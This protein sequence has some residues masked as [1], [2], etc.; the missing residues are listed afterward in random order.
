MEKI[1]MENNNHRKKKVD[2]VTLLSF[3]VAIFAIISL[4]AVGFNQVSFA[5]DTTL[6]G[7]ITK[8]KGGAQDLDNNEYLSNEVFPVIKY[9]AKYCENDATECSGSEK[10]VQVFCIQRD[11]D[12]GYGAD[13]TK[14]ATNDLS[15]NTG[16]LYLIS[17]LLGAGVEPMYNI[18]TANSGSNDGNKLET[19]VTQAAIWYYL[20]KINF[21]GNDV[22]GADIDKVMTSNYILYGSERNNGL[23]DAS[24]SPKVGYINKE[25]TLMNGYKVKGTDT[26]VEALVNE[27]IRLNT[28]NVSL[29]SFVTLNIADEGDV[30]I[31]DNEEYYFSKKVI[32][33]GAS[34]NLAS[35]KGFSITLPDDAPEGTIITDEEGTEIKDLT[36]IAPGTKFFIRVPIDSVDEAI[37]M[38][39]SIKGNFDIAT[40]NVFASA[41]KQSVGL[42]DYV[43]Y[44]KDATYKL[45]FT[46][47]P[48]TGS[49]MA[50]TIY[51]I[52]LIVLLCGVG[53]VYANA[54]NTKVKE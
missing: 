26:T 29:D 47:A 52:G 8:F 44:Q 45:E 43:P 14:E 15:S 42:L 4:V 36:N 22:K 11:K 33:Q 12:F 50:Q 41:D 17:N 54:K 5:T 1:Y 21:P 49:S 31:S 51:F 2:G 53:I 39:L 27:A 30:S 10:E 40:T 16:F 19:W 28:S 48:D 35:Y 38:D 18:E 20:N 24:S 3:F 13:Y 37:D 7:G 9:T 6:P 34:S 25:H 32:V 23:P 46:P